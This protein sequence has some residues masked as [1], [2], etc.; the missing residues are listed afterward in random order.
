MANSRLG[1]KDWIKAGF[2]ALSMGG[3]G[4]IRIE[5]IA[6]EIGTTKGSFY[7]HFKDLTELKN[8]M[9]DY[10]LTQ[11]TEA[12][13]KHIA[14]IINPEMALLTLIKTA[15][16]PPPD[17]IG[18]QNAEIAVRDWARWD[19]NAQAKVNEIDEMR[20]DFLVKNLLQ[21][22]F[23]EADA[24][25][26]ANIMYAAYVGFISLRATGAKIKDGLLSAFA[27]SVINEVKSK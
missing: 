11:G 16:A 23:N 10:Y 22:G 12:V 21:M 2:R 1:K 24:K 20:T 5:A 7:W 13:I 3:V 9:L 19:T 18:G 8:A 14:P 17:D 4:A 27:Q 6:R 25:V 15:T 26:R